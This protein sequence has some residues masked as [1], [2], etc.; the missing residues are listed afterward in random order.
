MMMKEV[1]DLN[2]VTVSVDWKIQKVQMSI[3]DLDVN[4]HRNSVQFLTK[5]Q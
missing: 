1:D 3:F 5:S 2:R 4:Q